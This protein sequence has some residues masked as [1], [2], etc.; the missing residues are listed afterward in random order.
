MYQYSKVHP[1]AQLTSKTTVSVSVSASLTTLILP[2]RLQTVAAQGKVNVTQKSC[3][4][5]RLSQT[6]L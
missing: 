1:F 2:Q 4:S 5:V 6:G 3:Q